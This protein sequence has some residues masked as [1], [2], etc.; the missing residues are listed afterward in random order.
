MARK[1]MPLLDDPAQ[2]TPPRTPSLLRVRILLDVALFVALALGAWAVCEWLRQSPTVA[3]DTARDLRLAQAC[4]HG[5]SC[6]R[7]AWSGARLLQGALWIRLLALDLRHGWSTETLH[8]LLLALDGVAAAVVGL[9][10][11]RWVA[12]ALAVAAAWFYL[13]A[14]LVAIHDPNLWNPS[15]VLLPLALAHA[16]L[17]RAVARGEA[18]G[19][20]IAGAFLALAIDTHVVSAALLPLFLVALLATARR[21]VASSSA[22]VI[23]MVAVLLLDSLDAWLA[24]AR[25]ADEAVMIAGACTLIAIATLGLL[26]RRWLVVLAPRRRCQMVTVGIA[27]VS[28][29]VALLARSNIENSAWRYLVI[30]LP[31]GVV[32]AAAIVIVPAQRIGDRLRGP[33]GRFRGAVVFAL[34]GPL[35]LWSGYR[36]LMRGHRYDEPANAWPLADAQAIGRA[37]AARGIDHASVREHLQMQSAVVADT[38]AAFDSAPTARP[39]DGDLLLLR[40]PSAAVPHPC[41]PDWMA[42]PIS[43]ERTAVVTRQVPVLDR[44]HIRLCFGPLIGG[45]ECLDTGVGSDPAIESETTPAMPGARAA[46]ERWRARA[47]QPASVRC[48]L[49]AAAPPADSATLLW[50][51]AADWRIESVDGLWYRRSS[52]RAIVIDGGGNHGRV[53]LTREL[54]ADSRFPP[55]LW[56]PAIAEVPESDTR[57]TALLR[58]AID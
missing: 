50:M 52:S 34:A 42:I 10:T 55:P 27:A 32:V 39:L 4:L 58:A 1:R 19:A 30:A 17:L 13:A 3:P 43:H 49:D 20:A 48:T 28:L 38:I 21:P 33:L 56:P 57:L 31:S 24:N 12:P 41:P 23:A 22:L 40:V 11:R 37:L 26:A 16:A 15:L 29:P 25:L 35:V 6:S 54:S 45:G 53:S 44:H 8:H 18:G 47:S 5:G 2:S 7:G 46:W 51:V 9:A 14:G 36:G